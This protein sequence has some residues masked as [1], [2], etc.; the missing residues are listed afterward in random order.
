MA[1]N[2]SIYVE[3]KSPS[4][5]WEDAAP[6]L[7]EYDH[8]LWKKYAEDAKGAGHGGMDF[9]VINAFVESVKRGIAP[10]I[11]V[12]DAAT[13]AVVTPLSEQSIEGGG[14]PMYFPDFTSGKWMHR[15]P[16]FAMETF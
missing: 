4:H 9:F 11:D 12:Y 16:S 1:V 8:P 7:E 2:K 5:Q 10:P 15:K 14:E 3:G 6:Y 13:W